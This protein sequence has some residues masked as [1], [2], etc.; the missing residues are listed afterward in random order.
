METRDQQI[1]FP[2]APSTGSS[3]SENVQARRAW[4]FPNSM[5]RWILTLFDQGVVS[6]TRFLITILV[7]RMAG[8]DELGRY[9]LAF[10]A[11]ILVGCFQEAIV[12]TPYAIHFHRLR[13][14][15]RAA[16]SGASLL[17]HAF[18][19]IGGG[20]ILL[21]TAGISA[22]G[23]GVPA[24]TKIGLVVATTLPCSLMWEFAR[25][26]L[27]AQAEFASAVRLDLVFAGLQ[28]LALMCFASIGQLTAATGLLAV[29]IGSLT[30]AFFWLYRSR[31][32]RTIH[33]RRLPM[34]WERNWHLGKWLVAGQIISALHSMVPTLLLALLAGASSTGVFAAYFNIALI[35]NPLILAMGNFLTSRT[36]QVFKQEGL[37]AVV[38]IV[39]KTALTTV[40]ALTLFVGTLAACGERVVSLVYGAEYVGH[41]FMLVLLGACPMTWAIS[42]SCACGLASLRYPRG[43]FIASLTGTLASM[44]AIW[45]MVP[46][47]SVTG[48]AAGLLFGGTIA[49]AMHVAI[50]IGRSRTLAAEGRS[51]ERV[52][53]LQP[54]LAS[55]ESAQECCL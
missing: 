15:S 37:G 10:S 45:L 14:R 42:A 9:S 40:G 25:R 19:A 6:G 3:L 21:A 33:W 39:R 31:T 20:L 55:R 50:F 13:K 26:S 8:P 46:V 44:V 43:G 28:L 16:Y 17:L 4:F 29:A 22:A 54:T 52:A 7:G 35:A 18:V 5:Q 30:A 12:T 49:A 36:A 11:L 23:W 34:Y 24:W 51:A 41:G 48:A 32:D 1:D 2:I 53:F 47:W 38:H 27:L